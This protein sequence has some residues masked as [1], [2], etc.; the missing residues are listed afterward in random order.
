[1]APTCPTTID[2]ILNSSVVLEQPAHGHGYRFNVDSLL[3]AQFVVK[4]HAEITTLVDLG[5]GTGVVT[6]C[7]NALASLRSAILVEIDPMM[8][9]IA[10]RNVE[11]SS[12]SGHAQVRNM[13]VSEATQLPVLH[14]RLEVVVSNPPYT[15]PTR[16]RTPKGHGRSIAR[17]GELPPFLRAM[18]HMLGSDEPRACFSYPSQ[19]LTDALREIRNAGMKL[20]RLQMVH[21]ARGR[22]ARLCLLELAKAGASQSLEMMQEVYEN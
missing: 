14:S 16:G 20:T 11:R 17:H 2:S 5:T 1:M 9:A 12:L 15:Q 7:I 3:L 18:A 6:L 21:A 13:D 4:A 10:S 8:C 19:H 22:P